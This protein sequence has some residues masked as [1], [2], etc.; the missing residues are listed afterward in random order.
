MK[1]SG[2]LLLA[3]LWSG[4]VLALDPGDPPPFPQPALPEPPTMAWLQVTDPG[5]TSGSEAPARTDWRDGRRATHHLTVWLSSR[6]SLHTGPVEV[7][8]TPEPARVTA[9][10]PVEVAPVEDG[11]AVAACIRPV[12]LELQ[13]APLPE[14]D[15]D[16][17]LKRGRRQA[18][19]AAETPSAGD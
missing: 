11:E 3:G 16:W 7:E 2:W 12:S 6:E 19:D 14:A 17:V 8:V 5:C 9:W 1:P 15:Y 10:I 13:V 4:A 18:A